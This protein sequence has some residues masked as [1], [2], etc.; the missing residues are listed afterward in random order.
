MKYYE[1]RDTSLVSSYTHI[2][3]LGIT[4]FLSFLRCKGFVTLYLYPFFLIPFKP[5]PISSI[6]R[7]ILLLRSTLFTFT[8]LPY[9]NNVY[10]LTSVA[11][12]LGFS[13]EQNSKESYDRR[14]YTCHIV[15][16]AT[17]FHRFLAKF[18]E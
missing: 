1:V 7:S 18:S 12:S 9:N 2:T 5:F 4:V 11:S 3:Y 10:I 15:E 6:N 16:S 13:F 8:R 17:N 14:P